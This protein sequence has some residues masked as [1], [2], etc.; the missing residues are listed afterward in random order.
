MCICVILYVLLP[1]N[2]GI[3]KVSGKFFVYSAAVSYIILCV[4][5]SLSAEGLWAPVLGSLTAAGKLKF[6]YCL[7]LALRVMLSLP[8][9]HLI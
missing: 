3:G 9:C 1:E 4:S 8:G 7:P 5:A 2:T 6:H